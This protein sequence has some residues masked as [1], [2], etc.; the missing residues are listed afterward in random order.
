LELCINHTHTPRPLPQ[1]AEIV[2][3]ACLHAMIPQKQNT[4]R[5]IQ[6]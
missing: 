3:T 5:L 2:M 4:S 6:N 1:M